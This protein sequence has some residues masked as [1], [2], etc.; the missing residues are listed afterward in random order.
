MT[1]FF[2]G[3]EDVSFRWE[4]ILIPVICVNP[5][6]WI[7]DGLCMLSMQSAT[8]KFSHIALNLTLRENKNE[9]KVS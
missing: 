1:Y 6:K 4:L 5:D 9:K 3:R 8:N 2:I 7:K